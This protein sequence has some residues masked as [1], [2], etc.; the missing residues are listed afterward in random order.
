MHL[1]KLRIFLYFFFFLVTFV[2][3]NTN[4]I[5]SSYQTIY[6][7]PYSQ[8]QP[9]TMHYLHTCSPLTAALDATPAATQKTHLRRAAQ[10]RKRRRRRPTGGRRPAQTSPRS[11]GRSRSLSSTSRSVSSYRKPDSVVSI[12]L[13]IQCIFHVMKIGI[14]FIRSG[15]KTTDL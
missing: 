1:L 10:S 12:S 3:R 11:T 15:K 2:F 7:S 8:F 9:S 13:R 4:L 6:V 5:F 14:I